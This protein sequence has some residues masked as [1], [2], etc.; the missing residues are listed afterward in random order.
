MSSSAAAEAGSPSASAPNSALVPSATS[1][2]RTWP[3]PP[4]PTPC[5]AEGPGVWGEDTCEVAACSAARQAGATRRSH[6]APPRDSR[7]PS[8]AARA[9]TW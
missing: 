8:R 2:G 4:A 1:S 9:A 7:D 3:L 6:L 5:A